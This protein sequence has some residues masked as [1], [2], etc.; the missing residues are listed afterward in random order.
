MRAYKEFSAWLNNENIDEDI[1]RELR[2]LQGKDQEIYDRFSKQ[3]EFGTGGL[4]GIV[5]A[6]TNRMNIY[7][8]RLA[9]Q[10]FAEFLINQGSI[11][12]GV[13][14]G[15]DP[16]NMSVEF[17]QEAAAVLI[18]N[19]IPVYIFKQV[20]PTPF[21]SFA[22]RFYR[23]DGGIMITASHNSKEYNGYKAYN[24]DGVQ[25]LPKEANEVSRIMKHLT[26]NDV[27]VALDAE[28]S[29]LWNWIGDDFYEVYFHKLAQLAPQRAD[30][31][32][33]IK[34]L[35]T[36]LHGTGA[37]FVP[38][39]LQNAGFTSV[40]CV[41]EQC[42]IDGS[43]PTLEL[44]NPEEP[45]AFTLAF[46][47]GADGEYDLILAT[48]PDGDRVGIA[49][50]ANER[51]VLLTGNHV[52]VLLADYLLQQ[53]PLNQYHNKVI[54]KTIV[55]TDMVKAVAKKYGV[56]IME[57][58]TGFKY[59]GAKIS[60]IEEQGKEF[61]FGFEESCG[62]LAGTFVRDKDAIMTSLLIAQMAAYYKKQGLTLV[63][64]LLELMEEHGHHLDRL[65]SYYF[66]NLI[67]A[68]RAEAFIQQLRNKPLNNIGGL[69]I[70]YFKDYQT[71]ILV[72]LDKRAQSSFD[73][74]RENVL[75]W[76][77]TAGD[78]IT[79][80]PSGTEPKMKLYISIVAD[81]F[82]GA[83]EKLAVLEKACDQIIN[84]GLKQMNV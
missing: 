44:P 34:I 42:V 47:Y 22:V 74:P 78:L 15:C 64:R 77:T 60:E 82:E 43:F 41:K 69:Q 32:L 71:G 20:V 27:K 76:E 36:A 49:V 61:L 67:E 48:D 40:D 63:E 10:A 11:D 3:L 28:N 39:A 81:Q 8:V 37:K 25:L 23:A 62:Y 4:R 13:T 52:G 17:V 19:N 6:G 58:L 21:L 46:N 26:L 70:K 45:E 57:T 50:F 72:D 5:G 79:L 24:K 12:Q 31:D 51:F 9:T 18:G 68:E 73:F 54:V 14:I 53:L 35:Y 83:E 55:S 1:K 7:T 75:Q 66:E 29:P 65:Q 16:R 38:R 30:Q 56:E 59:I 84:D 2:E 33:S 80:R